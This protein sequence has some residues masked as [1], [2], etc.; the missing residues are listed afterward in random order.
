MVVVLLLVLLL[1]L[2]IYIRYYF[3]N[4]ND[5]RKREM[6]VNVSIKVITKSNLKADIYKK[7]SIL[8]NNKNT[9]YLLYL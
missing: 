7:S 6:Y 1:L 5:R 9:V 2:P 8:N 3:A 4:E